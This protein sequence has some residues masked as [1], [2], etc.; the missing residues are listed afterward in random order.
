V[1]IAQVFQLAKQIEHQDGRE[2]ARTNLGGMPSFS[3]KVLRYSRQQNGNAVVDVEIVETPAS[4]D[5][6]RQ[7]VGMSVTIV[8]DSLTTILWVGHADWEVEGLIDVTTRSDEPVRNGDRLVAETVQL[9][10]AG[11]SWEIIRR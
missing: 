6:D 5:F 2:N 1:L 10:N 8:V 7:L 3:A 11:G 4:L 9:Q